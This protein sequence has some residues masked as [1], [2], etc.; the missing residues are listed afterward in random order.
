MGLSSSPAA[1]AAAAWSTRAMANAL[2]LKCGGQPVERLFDRVVAGLDG[3]FIGALAGSNRARA[4]TKA[5]AR[6]MCELLCV[7]DQRLA[8]G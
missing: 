8:T 4:I 1:F 7:T 2:V 5:I 6:R 3:Q